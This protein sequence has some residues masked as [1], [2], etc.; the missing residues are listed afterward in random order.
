MQRGFC[1]PVL[2][3]RMFP[4]ALVQIAFSG[5]EMSGDPVDNERDHGDAAD[6][7][8]YAAPKQPPHS[9]KSPFFQKAEWET[10]AVNP[11]T[12]EGCAPPVRE[13]VHEREC[14]D[15]S[16]HAERVPSDLGAIIHTGKVTKQQPSDKSWPR[17]R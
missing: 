5:R 17:G 7:R 13:T 12:A 2:Q 1:R 9:L 4:L 15:P 6:V 11:V 3:T 10:R 14:R 16:K 8:R